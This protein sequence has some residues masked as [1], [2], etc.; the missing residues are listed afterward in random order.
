MC[1]APPSPQASRHRP[2]VAFACGSASDEGKAKVTA[3]RFKLAITQALNTLF[4]EVGAALPV[5]LLSFDES[6]QE[7]ILRLPSKCAGA[8]VQVTLHTSIPTARQPWPW[9]PPRCRTRLWS[10]LTLIT[11]F[12]KKPCR[13]QVLA[14][15][16]SLS[17]LS[18]SPEW[19][20]KGL[21]GPLTARLGCC[22]RHLARCHRLH[23]AT[24]CLHPDR[25]LSTA[26]VSCRSTPRGCSRVLRVNL[27][28]ISWS[29]RQRFYGSGLFSKIV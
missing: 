8:H 12:E 29:L 5:D 20:S 16:G 17:L 1:A 28:Q 9:H 27:E 4:G 10:A 7:A 3:L 23:L 22:A 19:S 6:N 24:F 14:V 2:S 13:V 15:A 18:W 21:R 26:E 25:S 11:D